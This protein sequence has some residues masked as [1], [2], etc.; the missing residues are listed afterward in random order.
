MRWFAL[1]C[2][3]ACDLNVEKVEAPKPRDESAAPSERPFKRLVTVDCQVTQRGWNLDPGVVEISVQL[4]ELRRQVAEVQ[5][6]IRSVA[7]RPIAVWDVPERRGK[8]AKSQEK[9]EDEE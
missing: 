1:I 7:D 2:V 3:L 5:S 9:E 4:C 8:R 6:A